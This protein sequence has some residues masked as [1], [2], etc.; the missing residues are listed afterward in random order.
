MTTAN[1]NKI[2]DQIDTALDAETVLQC[3]NGTGYFDHMT[4]IDLPADIVKFTDKKG[5]RG[6]A[7]KTARGNV[8]FFQRKVDGE[9]FAYNAPRELKKLMSIAAPSN[10]F[11]DD[12]LGML[13]GY[14][15]PEN[16][17][18]KILDDVA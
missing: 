2:F 13:I 14:Y 17:V 4:K 18:Q 3:E 11:T 12:T 8:V 7:C 1:F 10:R 5:R 16:F 15:K 6:I 9:S